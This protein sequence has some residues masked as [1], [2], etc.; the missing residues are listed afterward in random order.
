MRFGIGRFGIGWK[1]ALCFAVP[2]VALVLEVAALLVGLMR[3]DAATARENALHSARAT[4]QHASA[5]LVDIRLELR[6][7]VLTR[8]PKERGAEAAAER[9]LRADVAELQKLGSRYPA[10]ESPLEDLGPLIDER[11]LVTEVTIAYANKNRGAL[12]DAYGGDKRGE[13]MTMFATIASN[14]RNGAS[15]DAALGKI[16]AVLDDGAQAATRERDTTLFDLRAIAIVGAIVAFVATFAV[17]ALFSRRLGQRLA[18]VSSA[19]ETIV[20]EDLSILSAALHRLAN[21]DLRTGLRTPQRSLH[22]RGN[23]EISVL[24]RSHNALGDGLSAI[25]HDLDLALAALQ[26]V[27]GGVIHAARAVASGSD[28]SAVAAD[29]ATAAVA[30]IAGN[31]SEIAIGAGSQSERITAASTAIEELSRAAQQ[32]AIAARQQTQALGETVDGIAGLDSGIRVLSDHGTGLAESARIGLERARAGAGVVEKSRDGAR[33]LRDDSQ[34]WSAAIEALV[35]RSVDATE[36]VKTI[37]SIAEQSNLLALNAAIEAARAGEHGRGFAV[38]ATEV[39]KLA[40]RSQRATRDVA[41]ILGAIERETADAA[42]AIRAADATMQAN[43]A[44]A[45]VA[46]EALD[47]VARS[48]EETD[49]VAHD[50]AR[51]AEEMRAASLRITTAIGSVSSAVEENAA[52]AGQMRATTQEITDAMLPVAASAEQQSAAA[53]VAASSTAELAAGIGEIEAATR[54]LRDQARLLDALVARFTIAIETPRAL[55][56]TPETARAA[57]S[58]AR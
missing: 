37:A 48:A 40:E 42:A 3:V 29:Q 28:E 39:R 55:E 45:E 13:R 11:K 20:E 31:A 36:I 17:G 8:D 53:H 12:L 5:E 35:R 18:D 16:V 14:T 1:L 54:S 56:A 27:V 46:G 30:S 10:L 4:A 47:G 19:L 9:A 23:D 6:G 57:A 52:S 7:Y 24:A 15:L 38:V 2:L 22:V 50:V 33:R 43:V 44:L 32:I 51:R 41:E 26:D 25:Q 21:G 49:R 58:Q 34:R